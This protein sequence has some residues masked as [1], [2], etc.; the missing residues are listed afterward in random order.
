MKIKSIIVLFVFAIICSCT[1][2][3]KEK[4]TPEYGIVTSIETYQ[5][6]MPSIHTY[7]D[8]YKVGVQ[9]KDT[10]IYTMK[11]NQ[12]QLSDSILIHKNK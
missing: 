1:N 10:L 11:Y 7:V 3:V 8:V 9:F 4:L 12:P 5:R 2:D 6:Y